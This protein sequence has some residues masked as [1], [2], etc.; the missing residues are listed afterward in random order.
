MDQLM[1]G[2]VNAWFS[3]CMVQL[4]HDSANAWFS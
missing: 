4:M 3:Q 2:S 1:H